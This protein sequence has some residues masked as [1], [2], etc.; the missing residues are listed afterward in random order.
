[1]GHAVDPD[2]GADC[3]AA[4]VEQLTPRLVTEDHQ[5][6]ACGRIRV[7]E[8]APRRGR[9]T[10]DVEEVGG[11]VHPLEPRWFSSAPGDRKES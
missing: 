6:A 3:L 8:H 5:R 10:E 2:L 1:V 11:D 9:R 4:A 7:G